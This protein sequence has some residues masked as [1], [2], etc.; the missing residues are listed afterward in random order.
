MVQ[1]RVR[2]PWPEFIWFSFGS[3][4]VQHGGSAGLMLVASDLVQLIVA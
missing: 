3:D 2:F 1:R 4:L